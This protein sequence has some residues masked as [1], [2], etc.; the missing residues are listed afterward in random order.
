[1]KQYGDALYGVVLSIVQSKEIA[2]D[3]MQDTFV[4]IWKNADSYNV[5]KGKLFTWLVNIARYTAIDRIRTMK[6]KANQKTL[7]LDRTVYENEQ[8]SVEA[9]IQDVGLHK[10]INS[11]E[12]KYST[13]IN[14]LYLQGFTQKEAAKALN[15]PLG[16]VKTRSKTAII[17]LRTLLGAKEWLWSLLLSIW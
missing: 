7:S 8:L 4:K 12:E 9:E 5:K 16:T 10:I 6:F 1:M 13:L 17:Q 3:V 14:L 2:E 15:I 11:L